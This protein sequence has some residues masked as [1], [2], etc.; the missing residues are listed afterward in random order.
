MTVYCVLLFVSVG[1]ILQISC[2]SAEVITCFLPSY[3]IWVKIAGPA[4]WVLLLQE[5]QQLVAGDGS[6]CQQ[7]L[8]TG[9]TTD[10]TSPRLATHLLHFF[11]LTV[12]VVCD[13]FNA[14]IFFYIINFQP[15]IINNKGGRVRWW[16]YV[17][18][19]D[20]S[21]WWSRSL[22]FD[23]KTCHTPIWLSVERSLREWIGLRLQIQT[24]LRSIYMSGI[25]FLQVLEKWPA[26]ILTAQSEV[27]K[28]IKV[29]KMFPNL[30]AL[31]N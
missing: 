2:R 9:L 12:K 23:I 19:M 14:V 18:M 29:W 28:D 26:F 24:R 10:P 13:S 15:R 11:L 21:V 16:G 27:S 30:L 7:A 3:K 5:R 31:S 25:S 8:D 20:R 22:L 17:A 4:V 1:I 6:V